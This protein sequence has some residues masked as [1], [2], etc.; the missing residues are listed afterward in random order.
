MPTLRLA[1]LPPPP[2]GNSIV[3]PGHGTACMN[4]VRHAVAKLGAIAG[5]QTKST[6]QDWLQT[7]RCQRCHGVG[8]LICTNCKGSGLR[9]KSGPDDVC[10]LPLPDT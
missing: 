5:D 1:S 3:E 8:E 6:G 10:E 4:M 7:N 9:F 2:Q